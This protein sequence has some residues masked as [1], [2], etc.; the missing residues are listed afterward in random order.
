MLGAIP[1]SLRSL[2]VQDIVVVAV[3]V[4]HFESLPQRIFI[5]AIGHG[6]NFFPQTPNLTHQTK[7]IES[8]MYWVSAGLPLTLTSFRRSGETRGVC[9]RARESNQARPWAR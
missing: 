2:F 7:P 6:G 3:V 8:W 4:E 1:A 5:G 9:L